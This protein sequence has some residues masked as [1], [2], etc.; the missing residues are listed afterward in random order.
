M[1]KTAEGTK[2]Q[3]VTASGGGRSGRRGGASAA[4]SG[5]SAVGSTNPPSHLWL[6]VACNFD[7]DRAIFSW[8][9][10]GRQ[11]TPLGASYTM[12]F[13]LP[14]PFQG[15][16]PALFNFN[17]SGKPGGYADFDNYSVEEPRARDIEREIPLGK[18]ITLTSCADGSCLASSEEK[19]ILDSVSA[20]DSVAGPNVR[21]KVIDCGTG[22]VALQ[23]TNGRFV[24]V[25]ADGSSVALKEAIVS[26][27]T[28][29]E[30]FQWINLM[31]G[32]TML[33]SLTNHRYLATEPKKPGPVTATAT[34]PTP[35]RK[36]GACFKWKPID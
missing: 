31:R 25:A 1:V 33:M 14:Q 15:V 9:A 13:Q 24:S 36:D 32:D 8:S 35:A 4:V 18:T 34:G 22:R 20:S 3:M 30:K 6:R 7:T 23:A 10:D 12:T 16:R 5:S 29:A 27:L 2:L 11:F 28:D 21:F 26:D 17:T 19:M